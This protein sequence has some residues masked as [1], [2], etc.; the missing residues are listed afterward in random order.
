[1]DLELTQEQELLAES[2]QQLL[3]QNQGPAVWP[4][5][6]EFGALEIAAGEDVGAVELALVAREL[7]ERLEPTPLI[8]TAA[9]VYAA[10]GSALSGALEGAT[11]AL[12]LLEPGGGW[13]LEEPAATLTNGAVD[14]LKVATG[15][16]AASALLVLAEEAGARRLALVP[17]GVGVTASSIPWIDEW[18]EPSAVTF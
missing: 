9:A 7:G 4:A 15:V 5:L 16:E 8:D 10:R 17:C 18:L 12:A 3:A 11:V 13:G 1:M 6:V 14:G 2:V